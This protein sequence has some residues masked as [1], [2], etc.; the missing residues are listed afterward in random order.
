MLGDPDRIQIPEYHLF[1]R[2]Q[3]SRFRATSP[4]VS[5]AARHPDDPL[6][7]RHSHLLALG[8]EEENLF[9]GLRG[10]GGVIDFFE[11]RKIK[12]WQA[13]ESGD[14]NQTNRPTRNLSSSQ[15]ACVNFL[16]ALASVAG[17][18]EAVLRAVDADVDSTILL[19]HLGFH[20]TVEF[21][22]IG[23]GGPLEKG[24][25]PVRGSGV[26][27]ADALVVA[28]I[29]R[30]R[31]G[32][33]FE[34]KL[35]EKYNAGVYKGDGRAGMERRRRYSPLYDAADSSFRGNIPFDVWLYDPLYQLMRL[36]LLG[37]RMVQTRE[38]GIDEVKLVVVCPSENTRFLETITSTRMRQSLPQAQTLAHVMGATLRDPGGFVITSPA[39]LIAGI[40]Q[41]QLGP[42]LDH[43]LSYHHDRYGW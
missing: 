8:Y 40:R 34:W 24:R 25:E 19:S 30:H 37:D 21:E 9:P 3:L 26:T 1:V 17:A 28:A 38:F 41:A 15:V 6:G 23:L 33:L 14:S 32:Y 35:G 39:N 18:L 29:Q 22:W 36:R 10:S 7:R 12:W 11:S 31:R 16:L 13:S 27:S 2:R 4:T 42:G 5:E 20:S 43:W